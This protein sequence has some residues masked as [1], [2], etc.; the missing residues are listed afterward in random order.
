ML[1]VATGNWKSISVT[2][3]R[4]CLAGSCIAPELMIKTLT[5]I[6]PVDTYYQRLQRLGMADAVDAFCEGI[7]F[8]TEQVARIFKP[9]NH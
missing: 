2:V 9:L 3:K 6:F 8:S 1:C 7:A 5:L 4:T